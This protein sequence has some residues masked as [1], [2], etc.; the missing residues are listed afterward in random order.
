M[1]CSSLLNGH[2]LFKQG[3]SQISSTTVEPPGT[4]GSLWLKLY[5][6]VPPRARSYLSPYYLDQCPTSS[7]F[8]FHHITDSEFLRNPKAPCPTLRIPHQHSKRFPFRVHTKKPRSNMDSFLN[9]TQ[10]Q[11]AFIKTSLFLLHIAGLP[12]EDWIIKFLIMKCQWKWIYTTRQ[13]GTRS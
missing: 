5:S 7:Y 12:L 4:Y 8:V 1:E 11:I 2:F 10:L 13:K 6:T 9:N 3:D